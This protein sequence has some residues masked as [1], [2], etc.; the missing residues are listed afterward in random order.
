MKKDNNKTI[1]SVNLKRR[2][3]KANNRQATLYLQVICRRKVRQIS[4]PYKLHENEWDEE[5][6]QVVIPTAC[7]PERC[8]YLMEI[9]RKAKEEK[10]RVQTIGARLAKEERATADLI[11]ESYRTLIRGN[12]FA[13]YIAQVIRQFEAE[14]REASARHYRSL[15]NSFLNFLQ[16]ENILLNDID[17]KLV[18]S[19]EA[20]LAAK[21]LHPNTISFYMRCLKALWNRAVNEG[22]IET[23]PSPF[24]QVNTG[25]GKSTKKAVNREVIQRTEQ[26]AGKKL[27]EQLE[28][29]RLFFLFC[30][31]AQGMAFID[32]A[33]LT[34]KNI[35]GEYLI[36]R[37]HKTGELIRIKLLPVMKEIIR[38]FRRNNEELLFPILSSPEATYNEYEKK[39]RL[40]NGQLQKLGLL[41]GARLSSY[42]CRH[43][44]ATHIKSIG[45]PDSL[46]SEGMGHTSTK[47]TYIYI[48]ATQSDELDLMNRKLIMGKQK[49]IKGKYRMCL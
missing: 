13:P 33:H 17:E 4:L 47:T 38:Y 29:A 20:W 44:W 10:L 14:G 5:G 43:S 32:L 3:G 24:R 15:N 39:L 22:I 18:K 16:A 27:P 28:R 21:N 2:Q 37:R 41:V 12:S 42:V 25:I 26:L 48:D 1:I 6:Q 30:Y 49:K 19:Y 31:Y 36:Y 7:L 9:N 35:Q 40:Y 11:V 46:I 45:A 34:R 23:R 8:L